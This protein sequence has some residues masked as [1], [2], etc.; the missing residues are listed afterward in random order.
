MCSPAGPGAHVEVADILR[1]HAGGLTLGSQQ[2]R[3]VRA[4]VACRTAALGGHLQVCDACGFARPAYNSCRNRHCPKCLVL[5]QEL[6]AEAQEGKLLPVAYFHAVFTVPA[7]L[8]P[9][10]R[11]DPRTCLT[12]LF[13]AVAE[14]LGAVG[15]RQLRA[16][17]GFTAVLHTWTQKLLYHPHLHCIVPGGGLS[18]DGS[19]WI[20]SGERFFLPVRVLRLVFRGKLLSKLAAALADGRLSFAEGPARE[21]LKRASR[22]TWVVYAKRPLAGPQQVVRYLSRYTHRIAISNSR[23]VAY[24]G[25]QVAF[26]WRDRAHGNRRKQ[27]RLPAAEFARRFVQHVL[28]RHFVRIRHYGLLSNRSQQDLELCRTLVAA[29]QQADLSPR[30]QRDE[31]DWVSNCMRIFGRDPLLCPAC[32]RGRMVS[33]EPLPPALCRLPAASSC[34]PRPPP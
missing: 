29:G 31:E 14:T 33:L 24:D 32:G 6:W 22:T 12:L 16:Q 7:Q 34:D 5:R 26:V 15:W 19:S 10:F 1:D 2:A 8:H 3:T 11:R 18:A 28:P 25:E 21:L 13:D 17:V 27:L 30:R 23:L 20:S 4:L 9:L